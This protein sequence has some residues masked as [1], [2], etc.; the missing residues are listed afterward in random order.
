MFVHKNV[1][2]LS[3]FVDFLL[4][5]LNMI[6]S[7]AQ[8]TSKILNV[9]WCMYISLF[10]FAYTNFTDRVSNLIEFFPAFSH[11]VGRK[12]AK[13]LV[14]ING[15][16]S[17][18]SSCQRWI[19]ICHS[20]TSSHTF[21]TPLPPSQTPVTIYFMLQLLWFHCIS[22]VYGKSQPKCLYSK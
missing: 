13:N 7:I 3:I 17:P 9:P 6:L 14:T 11:V 20:K 5:V 22:V 12:S 21:N 4:D 1:F 10:D 19:F 2:S 18:N 16:S 15:N 8:A